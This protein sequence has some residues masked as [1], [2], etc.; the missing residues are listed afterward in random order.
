MKVMSMKTSITQ[1]IASIAVLASFLFTNAF[2]VST[3]RNDTI[4]VVS[5]SSATAKYTTDLTQLGREGRLREDLSFEKETTRLIKVLATGGIRQPVIV[6]EDAAVQNM[7]VEQ[8]ALRIAKGTAPDQLAGKSIVKIE[9][10]ALFS[11]MHSQAE[12][13]Q[14]IDSIVN[15]AIAAKGQTIL[16]VD[17]LTNMVGSRAAS[18]KVF[19]SIAGGKLVI[20]GASSAVAYN[21]RIESQPEI[22]AYFAGILVNDSKKSQA[23]AENKPNDSDSEYRGDNVSPDLRE[24]MAQDPSGKKRVDVIIQAKDADN[25]A[26][27]ALM[28]DGSARVSDRIGNSD[29]LVVNLPLSALNTL[30]TRAFEKVF[31]KELVA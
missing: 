26:L 31:A 12:A 16:F 6:D 20:I 10:A 22:A 1:R 23:I 21:E 11:N 25:A 3:F 9:T 5:K 15:D 13:A 27:R 8:V 29:T 24:M 19:D 30:S 28:A 4:R 7:I 14:V 18:T 2:A 17:E